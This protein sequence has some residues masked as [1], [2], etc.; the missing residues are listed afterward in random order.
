MKTTTL[1]A[2]AA[3]TVLLACGEDEPE[4]QSARITGG[5]LC[6]DPRL[7]GQAIGF[8][9]G[10][11]QCGIGNAVELWSIGGVSLGGGATVDCKAARAMA[12]WMDSGMARAAAEDGRRVTEVEVAVTYA[13]RNRYGRAGGRLSEHALGNAVDITGF[14]FADGGRISVLDDW[15]SSRF[16]RKVHSSACGPFSTVLGPEYNAAH[17]DH[18]HFDVASGYS[19]GPFCR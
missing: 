8:V 12:N 2:L 13:C 11:G 6:G 19:S 17:R 14:R 1:T 5:G 4:R 18:F 3:F 15:A 16:L 7:Q 10:P 9:D